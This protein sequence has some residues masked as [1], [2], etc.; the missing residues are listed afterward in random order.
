MHILKIQLIPQKSHPQLQQFE[1]LVWS[2]ML[3]INITFS[4]CNFSHALCEG[5]LLKVNLKG[6]WW[7]CGYIGR[8]ILPATIP[9]R[10]CRILVHVTL[11]VDIR[12]LLR[13]TK[14]EMC[15]NKTYKNTIWDKTAPHVNILSGTALLPASELKCSASTVLLEEQRHP[16]SWRFSQ[17]HPNHLCPASR[18]SYLK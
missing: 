18:F 2:P 3:E 11:R 1:S 5:R 7:N 13:S 12:N 17:F 14:S 9:D 16:L 8:H 6:S 15:L 10:C 4:Q